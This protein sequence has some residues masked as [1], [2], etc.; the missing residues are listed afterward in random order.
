MSVYNCKWYSV[1]EAFRPTPAGLPSGSL[2]VGVR[3]LAGKWPSGRFGAGGGN[4]CNQRCPRRP[5]KGGQRF[6]TAGKTKETRVN[7]AFWV[8]SKAAFSKCMPY[9]QF[10]GGN[11]Q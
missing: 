8:R 5:C 7:E 9:M 3:R 1:L 10:G 4:V 11:K 6:L 2:V